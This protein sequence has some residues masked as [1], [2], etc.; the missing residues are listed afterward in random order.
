[1]TNTPK[2]VVCPECDGEGF[3]G[4]GFVWTA[5]EVEQEDPDEFDHMQRA[6]RRGDFDVPCATCKG[7][8]VVPAFDEFGTSAEQVWRE[9]CEYRAEVAAERRFG[10]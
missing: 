6:L 1:M 3:F 4:P 2:Y 9:E 8:R 7:Q 5:D 10:C